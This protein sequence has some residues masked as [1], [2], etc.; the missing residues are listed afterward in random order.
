MTFVL[1]YDHNRF[2]LVGCGVEATLSSHAAGGD[3]IVTSCR[4]ST[5]EMQNDPRHWVPTRGGGCDDCSGD[6][7]SQANISMFY[8]SYI[9]DVWGYTA[10]S[11]FMDVAVLVA[12]KRWIE[13]VWCRLGGPWW[14]P[15]YPDLSEVPV[16]LEW[17]INSTLPVY[18]GIVPD[19]VS[20]CP[21][22]GACNSS[23]S[24]LCV[25]KN[26]V[27]R[28]GYACQRAPGYHGNPYLEDGCQG[29]IMY[30]FALCFPFMI[31]D[32]K[33]FSLKVVLHRI[34]HIDTSN[35]NCILCSF[36]SSPG[37]PL[38][39]FT[40]IDIDECQDPDIY[41]CYGDVCINV[42]GMY[43]CPKRK[44]SE[45]LSIGLGLGFGSGALL[46]VLALGTILVVRR[47]MVRR[48][49]MVRQR[50]FT[51][52]RGQLL[53]KLVCQRT[54]IGERMIITLEELEKA[55]NNFD[56]SCEIGCGAHGTVYKGILSSQ[57]VVAIKKSKIVVQKEIDD[58]INEINQRNITKLIGCCL[59]TEVPLLV[60]EFISNG[61]LHSHL[62]VRAPISLSWR[63]RLRIATPIIHRDIKS[64][65]I[66]L[67]RNLSVKLSDFGASRYIPIDQEGIHT[68]VQGTL[69]YLDPMYHITGNLTE[70]SD[71]YS[72]GVLL[73]E[74]LT[75]KKP[76]SYRSSQG[77]ALANHFVTLL[78]ENNLEEI[79][80]PQVMREGNGE[81][82]DICLLA[83]MCVKP[84][85]EERPAMRHIEMTLENIQASKDFSSD[86]AD[87]DI[88]SEIIR[89]G[90][91]ID[92]G[93][94]EKLASTVTH[95]ML[96]SNAANAQAKNSSTP[97]I[98]N[99]Y[100]APRSS[101]S[102][103][104]LLSTNT[105]ASQYTGLNTAP[106]TA[107]RA[108]RSTARL[109]LPFIIRHARPTTAPAEPWLS[110]GSATATAK[111][112]EQTKDK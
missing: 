29:W 87:D 104:M 5:C 84:I 81:V 71:V 97:A 30:S 57:D 62:H 100:R 66:L 92:L 50:F 82:I 109:R 35:N 88:S 8:P 70:K 93:V 105:L 94:E 73:I 41:P 28:S 13:G 102:I 85:G 6:G 76:V 74:L 19:Y 9:V 39:W 42:P 46:L 24:R 48:K 45:G 21:S 55:T 23:H 101:A 10:S 32:S 69:G 7:C 52:N 86:M 99:V 75:R 60:F 61:T 110:A 106:S 56:K 80:D 64:P 33:T 63:D 37:A 77:L 90:V 27:L 78:S 111:P 53:Q 36:F 1:S 49:E 108:M 12:E 47:I 20:R 26:S 96:S 43:Q 72:F 91:G 68:A 79:L 34:K 17:A 65:N 107:V 15:P 58:F 89:H 11:P 38:L 51:Q 31:F 18:P 2:V 44:S 54:D 59:E 83:A 22:A 103:A 14:P 67:D 98:R 112:S 95:I 40:G 16:V 3:S 25:D 4:T